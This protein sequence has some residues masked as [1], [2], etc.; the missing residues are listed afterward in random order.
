MR[1]SLWATKTINSSLRGEL[2]AILCAGFALISVAPWT[3]T[4]HAVEKNAAN[5]PVNPQAVRVAIQERLS[6][7]VTSTNETRNQEQGALVDYYSAPNNH[8]LWI[9]ANGLT[10]RAKAVMEEI[11]KAHEYGLRSSDYALP[12]VGNENIDAKSLADA[13]IKISLAVLGYARDARGGRIEPKRLSPNLDP[14]LAL[15]K[16]LEVIE[17][18]AIRSDPAAYLRSFEPDQP[19]FQ[20]LRKALMA[21]RGGTDTTFVRIPDGPLLQLG[22]EHAQVPLLRKR[23]QVPPEKNVNEALF[24]ASVDAAVKQFKAAH[25]AVPDGIVGPDTRRLLN[26]PLQRAANPE[27]VRLILLNMERWRWLPQDLGSSYVTVNVPEFALRVMDDGKQVHAARVVVGSPAHQTPILSSEI[28]ELVF[29]SSW[30]V[31]DSIKTEELLPHILDEADA[32]GSGVWNTSVF[33]RNNLHISVGGR[34]IDPSGLDWS[35]VDIRSLDIYQPPGPGNM[36]GSV[37]F[38]LANKSGVCLHDTPQKAMFAEPVRAESLTTVRVQGADQLALMLLKQDQG[39]TDRRVASAIQNGYDQHIALKRT[40]PVYITYF[41]L[42][43]NDDGSISTFPDVYGHDARMAAAL[44][45][46]DVAPAAEMDSNESLASR[47]L[48]G[49][50]NASEWR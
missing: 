28:Q 33:E 29:N 48:R 2:K 18:I 34:E 40:I 26:Q 7:K 15:P 10:D 6:A 31:P 32:D 14:T 41:T 22:I 9:N 20:A 11:A 47:E 49:N 45:S 16:P 46:N 36:L 44:L 38:A 3:L 23:L 27:I 17:S 39:W 43:V 8:L 19:G 12:K 4:A 50:P 5:A 37:K 35:R 30:T 1:I 13:E 42:R 21:A 25:G 24:D